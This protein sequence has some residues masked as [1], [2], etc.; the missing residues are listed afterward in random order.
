[1]NILLV[2]DNKSLSKLISKKV[3]LVLGYSVD[4]AFTLEETK[5]FLSSGNY[6]YA[7][8]DLNLPDAPNGEVVDYVLARKIPS[9]VLTGNIDRNVRTEILKKDIIDYV[10]KGSVDDVNYIISNL[11]TITNNRGT[12]IL[13]VDDSNSV[14]KN[15]KNI[16][17]SQL[18]EVFVAAHGEE[19]LNILQDNSDIKLVLTD[20]SMP[21]IDG[22]ELTKE[23]R[24]HYSKEEI[25]IIAMSSL[26]NEEIGIKFLKFGANDFIKKPF[27]REELICRIANSIEALS[28]VQKILNMANTDYLSGAYNRR[29][30]FENIGSYYED[31]KNHNEPMAIGMID[32]DFFKKINDSYGHEVGDI[33]IKHLSDML[34]S[35]TKGSDIVSRFG[36]EEFCVALKNIDYDDVLSFFVKLKHKISSTPIELSDGRIVDYN[37]SIGVATDYHDDLDDMIN[38]ADMQLYKAKKE[39][40]NRVEFE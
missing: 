27:T 33:A 1:M 12:K 29:F 39:G 14:R 35:S 11:E 31:A 8:L 20:Y 17:S 16:L 18:F 30:F 13:V 40:R 19:A 5:S 21:V 2:E 7:L 9:I 34:R 10:F 36:G 32:I 24:K 37:V 6:D 26:E 4:C 25:S 38:A 3:E 23:I 28:N 15:I 22:L